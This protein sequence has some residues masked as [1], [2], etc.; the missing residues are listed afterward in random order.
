MAG[1]QDDLH[2]R[3]QGRS[4][5]LEYTRGNWDKTT[6]FWETV[7][8]TDETELD[9]SGHEDQQYVWCVKA[10]AYDQKMT[11]PTVK[12]GGGSLML[13]GCFSVAGTGNLDRVPGIMDSQ[14]YQ[15]IFK[16]ESDAFL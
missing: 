5:Q 8:Q 11:I 15:A 14:K 10:Q 4:S 7:Q 6:G 2:S 12:L 16:E 1:L 9:L 13:W 3:P